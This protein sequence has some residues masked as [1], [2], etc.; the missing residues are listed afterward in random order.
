MRGGGGGYG[1]GVFFSVLFGSRFGF[2]VGIFNRTHGSRVGS[3]SQT[4]HTHPRLVVCHVRGVTDWKPGSGFLGSR[5]DNSFIGTF[6]YRGIF[7]SHRRVRVL[8]QVLVSGRKPT[9]ASPRVVASQP[10]R[11]VTV[12]RA[13]HAFQEIRAVTTER[14]SV[15]VRVVLR[16]SN[17]WLADSRSR[18]ASEATRRWSIHL[19]QRWDVLHRHTPSRSTHRETRASRRQTRLIRKRPR[20]AF[21][22]NPDSGDSTDSAVSGSPRRRQVQVIKLLGIE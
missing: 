3:Q 14:G 1:L 15:S 16:E 7:Q 20:H 9:F 22:V 19:F 5:E 21:Q 4:K 6:Q 17:A 11:P 8:S 13:G 18:P 2:V 12:V 10:F